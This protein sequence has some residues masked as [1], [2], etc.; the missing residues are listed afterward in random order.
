MANCNCLLCKMKIFPYKCTC[1]I[2]EGFLPQYALKVEALLYPPYPTPH[3]PQPS[4][5]PILNVILVPDKN[6]QCPFPSG[7]YK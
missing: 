2:I 6:P 3:S 7:I 1:F 4:T 5:Y